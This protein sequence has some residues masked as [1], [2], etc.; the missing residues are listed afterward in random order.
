MRAAAGQDAGRA[1]GGPPP[2]EI[3]ALTGLRALAAT[4]VVVLHFSNNPGSTWAPVLQPIRPLI[5]SGWL[6]VDLFFVLSGF[7]LTHT[8]LDKI[9]RRVGVRSTA[10]FYWNRLSR[11]WPTW[12][13][14]MGAFTGWLVLKHLTVGGLHVHEP[15][16]PHVDAAHLLAQVL[17]VQQWTQPMVSASTFPGP[18]WSLSAEWLAYLVFPVLV[19]GLHRVRRLPAAVLAVGALLPLLPFAWIAAAD[20][21]HEYAWAWLLRIAGAFVAGSLT[22]LCVRRIRPTERVRRG[23][24]VLAAGTLVCIGVVVWWSAARFVDHAGVAVL[25]FP[26][27]VGALAFADRGPA[28][29]LSTPWMVTGG[30]ISFAVYLVHLFVFEVWWTAM[31]VV[32]H[33][34]PDSRL[35][36]LAAPLVLVAPFPLAWLTWRYV[37]E[38]ARLFMRRFAPQDAPR[39]VSLPP[40]HERAG[41]A[42]GRTPEPAFPAQRAPGQADAAQ[43]SLVSG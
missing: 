3:R 40:V 35:A 14:V 11:V 30:R 43:P 39:A 42:G 5:Q 36:S 28:R 29:L 22:G 37:E 34:Q 32:P 19:L 21:T 12:L 15:D 23:A 8:Y 31:D 38:P 20:A 33:L 17:M 41:A 7:V 2:G 1:T 24:S 27:L 13:V 26:V 18:G 9:G 10:A 25:A 6:G 16:Q 4:W